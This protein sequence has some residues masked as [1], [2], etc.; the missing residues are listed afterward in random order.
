[1]ITNGLYCRQEKAAL[2]ICY[3][4]RA[5]NGDSGIAGFGAFAKDRPQ[6]GTSVEICSGRFPLA[7]H[8]RVADRDAP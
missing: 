3:V 6:P 8:S 5:L 4:L 2:L 1:L 7:S